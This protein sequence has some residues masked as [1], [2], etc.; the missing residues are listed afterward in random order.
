MHNIGSFNN[1]NRSGKEQ[2][3][4]KYKAVNCNGCPLREKC[5]KSKYN[6]TVVINHKL[7]EHKQRVTELLKSEIGI[8]HRKKRCY[9]VEPVFANIKHIKTLNG[10]ILEGL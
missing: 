7:R 6:R 3:L 2:R 8:N 4:T 1:R 10:L 9:D 5:H